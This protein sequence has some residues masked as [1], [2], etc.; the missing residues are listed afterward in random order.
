MMTS[1]KMMTLRVLWFQQILVISRTMYRRL[2]DLRNSHTSSH[3][4]VRNWINVFSIFAF[5]NRIILQIHK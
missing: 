1:P 3:K 5:L 2:T 4:S